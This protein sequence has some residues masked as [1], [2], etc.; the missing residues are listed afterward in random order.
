MVTSAARTP[1]LW[2]A[3]MARIADSAELVR[4]TGTTPISR[5]AERICPLS[6]KSGIVPPRPIGA[7]RRSWRGSSNLPMRVVR[8]TVAAL[9]AFSGAWAATFGTVVQIVGGASDIV[10]DEARGRIYLVNTNQTRVEIYS[11]AQ[12]ATI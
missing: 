10:L 6:I 2:M 11:I 12:R 5:I 4:T 7:T 3:S 8:L 9:L 1:P